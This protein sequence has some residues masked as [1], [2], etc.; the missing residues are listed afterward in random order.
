[1]ASRKPRSG[2]VFLFLG[3]AHLAVGGRFGNLLET[4][5]T[6]GA[7][8]RS[9]AKRSAPETRSS[10]VVASQARLFRVT[11]SVRGS[12]IHLS[13]GGGPLALLTDPAISLGG[14]E[15][16][17]KM[18]RS[19]LHRSKSLDSIAAVSDAVICSSPKCRRS[20]LA[21]VLRVTP[22]CWS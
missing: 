11:C 6:R 3:L 4:S 15:R 18:L 8:R 10:R 9:S 17:V 1:S 2:G 7:Y 22:S 21:V 19:S 14:A 16:W 13:G 20:F 5:S 12:D